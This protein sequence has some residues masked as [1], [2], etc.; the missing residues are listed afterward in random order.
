LVGRFAPAAVVLIGAIVI[1]KLTP[2][3]PAEPVVSMGLPVR[4]RKIIAYFDVAKVLWIL[5]PEFRRYAQLY[6]KSVLTRQKLVIEPETQ[7]GF[8]D[9]G[10]SA[11][12]SMWHDCRRT[13]RHI[14]G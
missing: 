12:R 10:R 5:E 1:I 3:E 2:S 13:E 9:E 14:F 6:R 8:G 7:V 11:C 4:S